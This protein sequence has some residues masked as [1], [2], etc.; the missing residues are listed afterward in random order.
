MSAII[1]GSK[2]DPFRGVAAERCERCGETLSPDRVEWLELS[3]TD[4]KYYRVI[5]A[6]HESQGAFP[7]GS[8]CA[9]KEITNSK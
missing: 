9:K 4:G 5:P 1:K 2:G 8:T 3:N 7:F 6:G